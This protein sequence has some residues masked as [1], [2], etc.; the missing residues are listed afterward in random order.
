MYTTRRFFRPG[1]AVALGVVLLTAAAPRAGA[2]ERVA[3]SPQV[4]AY[5][6]GVADYFRLPPEEVFILGDWGLSPEEVPVVLFLSRR[7]GVSPEAIAAL[8]RNGRSWH[9][10]TNRYELGSEIY[11]VPL[12]ADAGSLT[13]AHSLF[14]GR[15]RSEW[16]ALQLTDA[17]IVSLV[18][19]K[20]LA[21][22]LG[23]PAARVLAARES[24]GSYPAAYQRLSPP[25]NGG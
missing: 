15:P 11:H 10:L 20:V 24:A 13:R 8:R 19:L 18:N 14:Q 6:R 5:F 3:H 21:R 25:S 7:A 17:E 16:A 12:P 1:M 9:E 23:I 22:V 2:Q 4:E